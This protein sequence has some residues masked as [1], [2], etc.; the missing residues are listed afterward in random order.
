MGINNR[1]NSLSPAHAVPSL[2]VIDFD[3]RNFLK[4]EHTVSRLQVIL[5]VCCLCFIWNFIFV[6]PP[7]FFFFFLAMHS[8]CPWI[9]DFI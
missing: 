1:L 6:L 3:F 8:F 4:V 9:S 5:N 2:S 7:L